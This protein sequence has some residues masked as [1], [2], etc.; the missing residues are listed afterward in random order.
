MSGQLPYLWLKKA[1]NTG[2]S[3]KI[4]CGINDEEIIGAKCILNF[5]WIKLAHKKI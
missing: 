2:K 3:A 1:K 4:E 5:A